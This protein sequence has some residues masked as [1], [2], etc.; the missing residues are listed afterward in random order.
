MFIPYPGS[1]FFP[2]WIPDPIFSIPDPG[3]ASKNLS[4]LTQK[5][6]LT[7]RKYD[8]GCSSRIGILIFYLSRIP[9]SKRQRILTRDLPVVA[10][11]CF[12]EDLCGGTALCSLP[13]LMFKLF[14]ESS[15]QIQTSL[16][17]NKVTFQD[18][19]S[20]NRSESV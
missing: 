16:K 18:S 3:S 7:S 13:Q 5:W 20:F 9:G 14:A 6:F 17:E 11:L 10:L 2:F 1:E 12:G 19:I 4:I 8:S 15:L